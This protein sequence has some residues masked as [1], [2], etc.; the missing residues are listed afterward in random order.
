MRKTNVSFLQLED[1]VKITTKLLENTQDLHD[2]TAGFG[3][4]QF[5]CTTSYV[6]QHSGASTVF[7]ME[8]L[9]AWSLSSSVLQYHFTDFTSIVPLILI[10]PIHFILLPIMITFSKHFNKLH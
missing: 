5:T 6:E 10:S 2:L 4:V 7:A 3:V 1:E 9:K 8:L